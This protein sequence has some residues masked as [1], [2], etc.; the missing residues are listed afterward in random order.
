MNGAHE[1]RMTVAK[2]VSGHSTRRLMTRGQEVII[3]VA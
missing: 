3:I 2:Q 1:Q